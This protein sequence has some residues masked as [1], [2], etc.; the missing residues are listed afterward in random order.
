VSQQL[1]RRRF[2]VDFIQGFAQLLQ[3]RIDLL[4]RLADH[5]IGQCRQQPEVPRRFVKLSH[6]IDVVRRLVG[7]GKE[8]LEHDEQLRIERAGRRA[9][10]PLPGG[11]VPADDVAQLILAKLLISRQQGLVV[12]VAAGQRLLPAGERSVIGG[13]K[14]VVGY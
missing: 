3:E 8:R 5:R 7:L 10:G 14:G 13:G 12:L 4:S 6:V 9:F 11:D 2:S 1:I